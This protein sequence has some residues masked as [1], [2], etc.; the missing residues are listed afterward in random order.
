MKRTIYLAAG[1]ALA[2]TAAFAAPNVANVSQKGSLMVMP[3]IEASVA[4]GVTTVIRLANDNTLP[5]WV[6]CYWGGLAAYE[7]PAPDPITGIIK[8]P[9]PTTDF[10]VA[11]TQNQPFV[12]NAIDWGFPATATTRFG[13][14]VCFASTDGGGNQKVFNHLAATATKLDFAKGTGF[15]YP[16]W[17]F[18]ARSGAVATAGKLVLDAGEAVSTNAY[19]SCPQYLMGQ[20]SPNGQLVESYTP[21]TAVMNTLALSSCTQDVTTV[22]KAAPFFHYVFFDIWNANERKKTGARERMDSWWT[23]ELT[24]K[25]SYNNVDTNGSNFDFLT[26]VDT[27]AEYF[28]V[29][30][31][32]G[33]GLLGVL[34]SDINLLGQPNKIVEVATPLTAAGHVRGEINWGTSI[35]NPPEKM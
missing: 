26:S 28:R 3:Y 1:M 29:Q 32:S 10:A 22:G 33:Y 27:P 19:D 12:F 8:F 9:K 4:D 35:E 17:S 31:E 25:T 14:L 30:S 2:A 13:E 21:A 18:Y 34:R 7:I 11:L 6:K 23:V 24:G 16:A 5:T 20:F 15:S